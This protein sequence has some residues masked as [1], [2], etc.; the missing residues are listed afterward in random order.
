MSMD[1]LVVFF[2]DGL[3]SPL[4]INR[5]KLRLTFLFEGVS[6]SGVSELRVYRG[7]TSLKSIAVPGLVGIATNGFN[8]WK[9]MSVFG[10]NRKVRA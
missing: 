4:N 8:A 2:S 10:H 5:W 9:K 6:G 3:V 1:S 7:H